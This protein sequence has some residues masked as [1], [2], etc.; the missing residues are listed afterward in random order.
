MSCPPRRI[1]EVGSSCQVGV[2]P[3]SELSLPRS[4]ADQWCALSFRGQNDEH[5]RLI[6][7]AYLSVS[8]A[9]RRR[10]GKES[11]KGPPDRR[12][13]ALVWGRDMATHVRGERMRHLMGGLVFMRWGNVMLPE[14]V[15]LVEG[16]WG[17][18]DGMGPLHS[19]CTGAVCRNNTVGNCVILFFK[20]T[21]L[22]WEHLCF[23]FTLSA[24]SSPPSSSTKLKD[25]QLTLEPWPGELWPRSKPRLSGESHQSKT[26]WSSVLSMEP[27]RIMDSEERSVKGRVQTFW[28]ICSSAFLR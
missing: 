10:G 18:G 17:L 25:S 11:L 12:Q 5:A 8:L 26:A 27:S 23:L 15:W 19:S 6:L 1:S 13:L 9:W 7:A 24:P 3:L 22:L 16:S 2:M 4:T 20:L 28:K 14:P 21:Y